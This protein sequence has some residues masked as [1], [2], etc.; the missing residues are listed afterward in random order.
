MMGWRLPP[1]P[2]LFCMFFFLF[3]PAMAVYSHFLCACMCMCVCVSPNDAHRR[4]VF[5]SVCVLKWVNCFQGSFSACSHIFFQMQFT[6][7]CVCV[8]VRVC[9]QAVRC[10]CSRGESSVCSL[11][12]GG[13]CFLNRPPPGHLCPCLCLKVPISFSFNSP[14]HPLY[15]VCAFTSVCSVCVRIHT[16]SLSVPSQIFS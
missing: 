15:F 6:C 11:G 16:V 8:C 9:V 3:L 2:Q 5:V 10:S 13:R 12:V 4:R 1:P 14:S 7:V